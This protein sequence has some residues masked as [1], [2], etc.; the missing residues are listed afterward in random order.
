MQFSSALKRTMY[1]FKNSFFPNFLLIHRAK[2]IFSRDMFC[3]HHFRAK[4]HGVSFKQKSNIMIM[5]FKWYLS[6]K[7]SKLTKRSSILRIL[8]VIHLL[9][10]DKKMQWKWNHKTFKDRAYLMLRIKTW[11]PPISEARGLLARIVPIEAFWN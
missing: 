4:I 1:D 5:S 8:F 10:L 6:C 7:R 3:L 2:Y 9:G 11:L